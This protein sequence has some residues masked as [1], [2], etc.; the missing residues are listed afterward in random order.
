MKKIYESP[1]NSWDE[2]AEAILVYELDE[3][4][5]EGLFETYGESGYG[6]IRDYIQLLNDLELYSDW[7]Y[8][9]P[10]ALYTKYHILNVS[11]HHLI[12]AREDALNV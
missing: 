8:V 4:E 9:Q 3:G 2:R 5:Y 6:H 1:F 10:G 12:I 11:A 7:G